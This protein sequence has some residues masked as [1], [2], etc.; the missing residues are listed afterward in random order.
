MMK[1]SEIRRELL[2]QHAQ[3]RI[4]MDV[5]KTI[6]EGAHAGLPGRGDLLDCVVRLADNIRSHNL[7]E[8]AL[9]GELVP[10]VDRPGAARAAI[11]KD[12]HVREHA[13]LDAAL[14]RIPEVPPQVAAVGVVALVRLLRQ[15]M[16][17]E[18]AAFLGED[19]LRDD[20]VAR[21]R[22]DA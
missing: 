11:M 8:E 22:D 13:R 2:A 12:E 9:L 14:R 18:E 17:R 5:T 1:R 16:D 6:A 10:S 19:V 7:R 15:H 3:I 20:V 21:E 4:M